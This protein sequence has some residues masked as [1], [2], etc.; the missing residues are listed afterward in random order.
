MKNR[1][2]YH[3]III[4]SCLL[5]LFSCTPTPKTGKTTNAENQ[6]NV[7][8]VITDDQGYGDLSCHGNPI[9][10]TPYID[11]FYKDAVRLTDFHVGPTC[12]P[13][14]AGLMTGRSANR[15]GVWHTIGGCS[16][17]REEEVTIANLFQQGDYETGLFGKWHL[18]DTYPARPQDKGFNHVVTH[19]GG[20]VGQTPDYW[21][22]DYFDDTYLVNGNPKKFDGYCTDVW[23]DEAMDFIDDK[24]DKP[25]FCYISTNAPHSPF[26]VP[27]EYYNQYKDSDIPEFQKRFYGMITNVDDNFKRLNDK[28]EK[29]G[30]TE[31]TIVIFMTDNGTSAGY[32]KV[33]G[34]LHGFNAGMK[35]TKNSE[36]EGGHR[37]PFFIKYP[38]GNINGGKDVA[39]L[40]ANVDFLPTIAGL[41][42]LE[43]PK[44]TL[45]GK[46][47]TGLL[48]G[49]KTTLNRDYLITDS[50]RMQVPKK[51]NKSAVMSDKWRLVNGKELYDLTKDIG[52][53]NDLAKTYPEKVETLREYYDEWWTSVSTQFEEYPII[54]LGSDNQNPIELTCHDTHIHS[55]TIPWHQNHVRDGVKN[56]YGGTFT[57]KFAESGH[58]RIEL[59]RWPFE[60]NL[61]I[62]AGI[63]N[64]RAEAVN[65]DAISA[66]K[67]FNFVKGTLKIGTW[68]AEEKVNKNSKKL[69]FEGDFEKGETDLSASFTT[70]DNENWGGFYLNVERVEK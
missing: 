56:P 7:I 28:L 37:V 65:Y 58:Y 29:L 23:F 33:K 44:K 62:N 34:K 39:T 70:A 63:E 38:K 8:V 4:Y 13:T 35:G 51:W 9:V 19:G 26:N 42:G 17:L 40:T 66:G 14:R 24:K 27:V 6:P 45:D 43:I 68:E 2:T 1:T 31:N 69:V 25:F 15:T 11:A 21:N 18:G 48:K 55:S 50:Q 10:K 3:Q 59:S 5:V 54:T 49:E 32:K 64:G 22:N 20:G 67:A 61:P 52:Q 16:I 12:A 41:C 53:E 47:L 57:V 30:L 60:A 46:D 36:Y